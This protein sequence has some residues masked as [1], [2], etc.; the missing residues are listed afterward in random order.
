MGPAEGGGRFSLP[1]ISKIL[2]FY[3]NLLHFKLN[4]WVGER[5]QKKV[6]STIL[7]IFEFRLPK[8]F[9]VTTPG[10]RMLKVAVNNADARHKQT[11]N[12]K[13]VIRVM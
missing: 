3:L 7:N 1:T 12:A 8:W 2:E 9:F 11:L 5:K 6:R 10:N 4:F 13:N